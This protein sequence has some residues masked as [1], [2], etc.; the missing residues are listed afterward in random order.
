MF[1]PLNFAPWMWGWPNKFITRMRDAGVQ[2]YV[3]G[4]YSGGGFST[5][6]DD[7]EQLARLPAGYSGG[8][9]TNHIDR[10]GPKVRGA[11]N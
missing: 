3:L 8:I 6:V 4:P 11:A 7:V 9:W 5:G 2:V 1:V 10:I